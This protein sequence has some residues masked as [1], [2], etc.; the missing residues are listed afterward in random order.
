[1]V[2][3]G[4]IISYYI[5][6]G[7]LG[8]DTAHQ[9]TLYDIID[10]NL[11]DTCINITP[12]ATYTLDSIIWYPQDMPPASYDTLKF[13]GIIKI[14][15][16]ETTLVNLCQASEAYQ[17]IL[18]DTTYHFIRIEKMKK[19]SNPISGTIV[20]HGVPIW[21]YL[22]Y[23]SGRTDTQITIIDTLSSYLSA[24]DSITNGG[25]WTP[26]LITW[27][28]IIP[29]GKTGTVSFRA[30]VLPSAPEGDTIYNYGVFESSAGS[31][32]RGPTKH[33]IGMPHIGIEKTAIPVSGSSVTSSDTITYTITCQNYGTD[34]AKSIIVQDTLSQYFTSPDI[35]VWDIGNIAPNISRDT[36]FSRIVISNLPG[37][38]YGDTIF[39]IPVLFSLTD[40][41]IHPTKDTTI[42]LIKRPDLDIIKQSFKLSGAVLPEFSVMY[43]DSK[44]YYHI[45]INN[46]GEVRAKDITIMDTIKS[47]TDCI[48]IDS[49]LMG[50]DSVWWN[51]NGGNPWV[52]PNVIGWWEPLLETGTSI[53]MRFRAHIST[54]GKGM[55]RLGWLDKSSPYKN[56]LADTLDTLLNT[57][58]LNAQNVIDTSN[59]HTLY[60]GYKC[61][62]EIQPDTSLGMFAAESKICTLRV[63]N[64]G[65]FADS[66][67]VRGMNSS[68]GWQ[69]T[70]GGTN[71]SSYIF[72]SIPSDSIR[73]LGVKLTAPIAPASNIATVIARS[74]RAERK[75]KILEDTAIITINAVRRIVNIIVEPDTS[76][77]TEGEPEEYNYIRVINL[78]NDVDVIDIDVEKPMDNWQYSITLEDG[79]PLIDTDG[80][81]KPDI[82]TIL[83][84]ET[85]KL[86]LSLIPPKLE[87]GI[88][89]TPIDT[90]V[91]WGTSSHSAITDSIIT[92]KDSATI[93]TQL[94]IED[95]SVHNVP[96]PF[97]KDEGTKFVIV[98]PTITTC[99]LTVYSRKGELIKEV[100]RDKILEVGRH[101]I[102]WDATNQWGKKIAAGTYIYK[103]SGNNKTIIKKLVILPER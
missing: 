47:S 13:Q 55:Q 40:T 37:S 14:N 34:T 62:V 91:I 99:N 24:P 46:V 32:R 100:L 39:N 7:N 59:T 56:E 69:I 92:P 74:I 72:P 78:G 9:I 67:W 86:A 10:T 1:V 31:Y 70:L 88:N 45:T 82:G 8:T 41:S 25:I 81:A 94:I 79:S 51:E 93:I 17:G 35:I 87:Q 83:A 36:T 57:C 29:A 61:G 64:T 68:A 97:I 71:D 26:P 18:L 23:T 48:I 50:P 90:L 66:V 22:C 30:Y 19:W 84:G 89:T 6:M 43:P 21:Y 42:H 53:Q 20:R 5:A 101:E 76:G 54:N 85:T 98:L 58:W 65:N 44:F 95:I 11:I 4:D 103:F 2:A 28:L 3:P 33:P 12:V 27:S 38:A 60:V 73:L 52:P 63:K 80:D 77:T 15:A 75:N 96:N 102:E 49:I 16:P